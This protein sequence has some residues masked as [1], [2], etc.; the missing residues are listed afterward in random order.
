MDRAKAF[1]LVFG[2][3]CVAT[4]LVDADM[5]L[6]RQKDIGGRHAMNPR[7]RKAFMAHITAYEEDRY[8]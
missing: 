5:T 6:F 1:C 2:E 7:R 4:P 8:V 3:F